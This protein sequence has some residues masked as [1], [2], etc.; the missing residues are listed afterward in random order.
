MTYTLENIVVVAKVLY[1]FS[2]NGYN[3]EENTQ[4]N[5]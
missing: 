2:E 1:F 4:D 3:E 5:A